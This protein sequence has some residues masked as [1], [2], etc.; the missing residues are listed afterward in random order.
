MI[1][2]LLD[3]IEPIFLCA[4]SSWRKVVQLCLPNSTTFYYSFYS[5][6]EQFALGT[7]T[8]KFSFALNIN[9]FENIIADSHRSPWQPQITICI[10]LEY[11]KF[12]AINSVMH[13][14]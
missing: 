1:N 6:D 13:L 14:D 10:R 4:G 8:L 9:I 2:R 3:V 11:S 12:Y 5:F 7:S